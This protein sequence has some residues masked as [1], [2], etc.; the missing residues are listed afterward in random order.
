FSLPQWISVD[1]KRIRGNI[2]E[3]LSFFVPLLFPLQSCQKI[4][5]HLADAFEPLLLPVHFV[6]GH[7]DKGFLSQAFNSLQHKTVKFLAN[8]TGAAAAHTGS[9]SR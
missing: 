5:G 3:A 6:R 9:P 4:G 7:P 2:L 8:L 1:K